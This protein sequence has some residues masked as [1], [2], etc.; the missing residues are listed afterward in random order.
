MRRSNYI[1]GSFLILLLG[2]SAECQT[3]NSATESRRIRNETRQIERSKWNKERSTGHP[4]DDSQQTSKPIETPSGDAHSAQKKKK[5][6]PEKWRSFSNQHV[7][8]QRPDVDQELRGKVKIDVESGIVTQV[9]ANFDMPKGLSNRE[10]SD[11][12]LTTYH[13][14]FGLDPDLSDLSFEK[15]SKGP[16]STV[17]VYKQNYQGLPVFHA[18]VRVRVREGKVMSMGSSILPVTDRITLPRNISQ[19]R[20]E[21]SARRAVASDL[22]LAEGELQLRYPPSAELGVSIENGRPEVVWR[23][24]LVTEKPDADLVILVNGE[25]GEVISIRDQLIRD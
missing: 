2:V 25:S 16:R 8:Q 21:R 19:D 1:F 18:E 14:R 23:V 12:F 5:V 11:L 22:E 6:A 9:E 4:N 13:R 24:S 7:R 20:A 3:P 15:E 17:L 10:M